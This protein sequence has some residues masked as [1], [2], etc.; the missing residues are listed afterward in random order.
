MNPFATGVASDAA[1]ISISDGIGL[2]LVM[3][4]VLVPH[5]DGLRDL[6]RPAGQGRP[7]EV[8]GLAPGRMG[9]TLGSMR[10]PGIEA[11]PLTGRQKVV[12]VVFFG[13]V[14]SP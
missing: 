9:P 2:R 10:Q 12:L 5:V 14:R 8:A 1:G 11:P 13:G 4:V 7:D 3:L 6:V